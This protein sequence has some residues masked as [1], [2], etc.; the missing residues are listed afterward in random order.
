MCKIYLEKWINELDPIEMER[1]K[2]DSGEQH[3]D[4][5]TSEKKL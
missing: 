5:E 1:Y 4:M 2:D 3:Q